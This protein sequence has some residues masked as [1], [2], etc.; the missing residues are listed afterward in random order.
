MSAQQAIRLI[1]S[2]PDHRDDQRAKPSPVRPSHSNEETGL[3]GS[4]RK[5]G[6]FFRWVLQ[7]WN[8]NACSIFTYVKVCELFLRQYEDSVP[9]SSPTSTYCLGNEPKLDGL[10]RRFDADSVVKRLLEFGDRT[11]VRIAQRLL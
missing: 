9:L 4:K 8:P 7:T 5:F 11:G 1:P 10:Y 6:T 2:L 3:P